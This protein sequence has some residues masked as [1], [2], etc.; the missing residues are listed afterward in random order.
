MIYRK[1]LIQKCEFS[2]GKIKICQIGRGG[3]AEK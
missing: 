1:L 2:E 3:K